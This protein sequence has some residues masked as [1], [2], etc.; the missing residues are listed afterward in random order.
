MRRD[1]PPPKVARA[2]VLFG[3]VVAVSPWTGCVTAPGPPPGGEGAPSGD[4]LFTEV[5]R[6]L[7][8]GAENGPW[9]DGRFLL[10]GIMQGRVALL[11]YDNDT[12]LD[13]LHVRTPTPGATQA[14]APN[15]LF[16]QQADGTF[17]N[18][19]ERAGVG[20]PGFGQGVAVGDVDND[21]DVDLYVTNYGRDAFYLNRG[22]G[23]F[24]DATV[25]A[26]FSGERWSSA[27]S[28][29]D[30]DAD[31]DLD[32]VVVHYLVYDF[33]RICMDSS[34]RRDYCGPQ[35]FP[36]EP[37][38]LYRNDG[39]ATFTD[40]TAEAG[41]V[42]S[43]GGGRARG[44][45]VLCVDLTGDGRSDIFVANDGEA[46][47]LWVNRGDATFAEEGVM[48]GVAVSGHGKAE[49]S[50]GVALADVNSDG[51]LDLFMTHL[52]FEHNRLYLG[53]PGKLFMDGTLESQVGAGDVSFTGFGCALFDYDHDRQ[54]DIA[55]VNGS[56]SRVTATLAADV[57]EFWRPYAERNSLL[58]NDGGTFRDVV[59]RSGAFGAV[60]EVSRGLA[61][62]DLD[63]DGDL[64][65]VM[66]N[67][68]NT[69]RVFRNDAPPPGH[70]WL[71][72]RAMTGLR[73]AVGAEVRVR[74]GD[75]ERVA[76]IQP[77][78]SYLSS[79]DPPAHFGL[80]T[81]DR[82]DAIEVRW[83][84]GRRE[85]FVPEGIDRKVTVREGNG[86]ALR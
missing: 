50:M 6:D 58:K 75:W 40:V 76:V 51:V 28:F 39:G 48:R 42:L 7:G 5:T 35:V 44:L 27:A 80:G 73:D 77:A 68:D 22:D 32:L 74:A 24:E 67:V 62:G 29:C 65:M 53:G 17:V 49:A 16:E 56:V 4:A 72:V 45:G 71:I 20:D 2:A 81:L 57:P 43:D 3:V 25:S 23:T 82:V 63:G 15:R 8:L 79:N 26:G 84:S 38:L 55:V 21:G 1:T 11:D 10:P 60:A 66:S 47:H 59:D 85:R 54:I 30:Y 33:D 9:P 78:T 41:L 83:P 12:D 64:D 52:V 69:L 34:G 19:T 86:E 61:V 70:H 14:P 13:I 37:D 31:G 46:N 18:V 36:G